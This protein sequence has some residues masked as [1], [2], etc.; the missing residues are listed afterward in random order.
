MANSTALPE[1]SER[2]L[3]PLRAAGAAL[4]RYVVVEGVCRWVAMLVVLVVAHIV[5]DRL[6]VLGIGPRAALLVALVVVLGRLGWR[7]VIRPATRSVAPGD[8][9]AILERRHGELEGRLASAV[10]FTDAAQIDPDRE[11]PALVGALLDRA[12]GDIDRVRADG[13]LR[14]DRHRRYQLLGLA[15]AGAIVAAI[16]LA[17]NTLATYIA[18]DVLLRDVAWPSRTRITLESPRRWAVGDALT[19][20]ARAHERVPAG[21]RAE[22]GLPGGQRMLRDMALRGRDEFVTEFG[23]IME[24]MRVRFLISKLGVDEHTEWHEIEAI[25]RPAVKTVSMRIMPP[26]YS[27]AAPFTLPTGQTSAEVLFGSRMTI[28]AGLNKPVE[29]ALLRT[30]EGPVA[31]AEPVSDNQIAVIFQPASSATY[32][33]ELV[34]ADG[35]EDLKPVTYSLRLIKDRAPRVRLRIPGVRDL[36]T[37]RATLQLEADCEDNLG[38]KSAAF[39]YVVDPAGRNGAGAPVEVPMPGFTSGRTRFDCRHRLSLLPL[40][41]APGDRLSVLARARD[42]QPPAAALRPEPDAAPMTTSVEDI[43]PALGESAAFALRVVTPEE[44]LAELGRREHEWRRE[45]EQI[46]RAQEQLNAR[47]LDLRTAIG[48]SGVTPQISARYA[49][50]ARTQR[51]QSGRL[52]RVLGE[53]EQIFAELETNELVTPPVRRRLQDGVIQPLT[54]LIREEV[55]VVA[56]LTEQLGRQFD[57]GIADELEQRQTRLVRSLYEVLANMIKWEG[58][59]EAVAMLRDI[60]R[61]QGELNE[62][63]EARLQR[64]VEELFEPQASPESDATP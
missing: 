39:A 48:E 10:A 36:V 43:D 21:L 60:V 55:S 22:F 46:I 61:L 24:S 34:D 28:T 52:K 33:F 8:V 25:V 15:A 59:N 49:A 44:L 64:Q 45:F 16:A 35:F 53:F 42:F 57:T 51:Q 31:A 32:Y 11:S 5:L 56:E 7:D 30:A 9:A 40:S 63:T 1:H 37:P 29:T 13:F 58:Y 3:R 23:P 54:G 41:L 2:L 47:A 14:R 19:V 18:R 50:E 17:P 20:V 4:R 38:L 27:G 6:L 12:A 26:D 62:Q